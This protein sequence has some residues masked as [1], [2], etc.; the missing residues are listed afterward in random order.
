V[1]VMRG[2][3]RVVIAAAWLLGVL[4]FAPAAGAAPRGVPVGQYQ[5]VDGP[6]VTGSGIAWAAPLGGFGYRVVERVGGRDVVVRSAR[7]NSSRKL[8]PAL[9]GSAEALALQETVSVDDRAFGGWLDTEFITWGKLTGQRGLVALA[10][11]C[12]VQT[13][14]ATGVDV[15]GSRVFSPVG[16]PSDRSA[17]VRSLPSG[18]VQQ[19]VSGV[20][21]SL[22]VAGRYAAWTTRDPR[23]LSQRAFVVW[24][25]A[26]NRE[27]Y[28][29]PFT[30]EVG[31]SV[32]V[33]ADG[34]VAFIGADLRL[35]WASPAEPYAHPVPGAGRAHTGFVLR[36]DTLTW[37]RSYRGGW[38]ISTARV[39]GKPR[40]LV[41]GVK[42]GFDTDGTRVAWGG[43]SCTGA[44]VFTERHASLIRRP[45]RQGPG[46]RL[47]LATRPRV[48]K[49]GS[50]TLR[51]S[52]AGFSPGCTLDVLGIMAARSS[53]VGGLRLRA[54]Q[55]VARIPRNASAGTSV[56]VRL[57]KAARRVLA[58]R[59]LRIKI[60]GSVIGDQGAAETRTATYLLRR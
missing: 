26:A 8:T 36:G 44:V 49:N 17:A 1:S 24:D 11:P 28:R 20:D 10:M 21:S 33:Q 2:L 60:R 38:A 13:V 18:A 42:G 53:S 34:K 37:L 41:S 56:R 14:C 19:R 27:L 3:P 29:L 12:R 55:R 50:V 47:R 15:D 52:C 59:P 4:V 6:V 58:R 9:S 5:P 48:A 57:T 40:L 23:A 54:G 7:G 31:G 51:P 22:S 39:G 32:D 16:E 25:L 43:R 30:A 45:V 35:A 46:C